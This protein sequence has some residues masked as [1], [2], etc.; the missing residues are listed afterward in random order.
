MPAVRLSATMSP[1]NYTKRVRAVM[2]LAIAVELCALARRGRRSQA[3]K[4]VRLFLRGRAFELSL[5]ALLLLSGW[6]AADVKRLGHS[7]RKCHD[8]A[9]KL[10]VKVRPPSALASNE[11][12]AFDQLYSGKRFEYF[13]T[14]ELIVPSVTGTYSRFWRYAGRVQQEVMH[15]FLAS[16]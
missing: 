14:F 3:S 8:A 6:S 16:P 4:Y 10:G 13:S 15:A 9:I 12:D 11:L 2:F 7:L 5:K 1:T